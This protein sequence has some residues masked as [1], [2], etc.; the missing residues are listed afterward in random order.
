MNGKLGIHAAQ[1]PDPFGIPGRDRAQCERSI[2]ITGRTV[3]EVILSQTVFKIVAAALV[4]VLL[5]A[6]ASAVENA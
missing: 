1:F 3:A 2:R 5:L 4:A 6:V